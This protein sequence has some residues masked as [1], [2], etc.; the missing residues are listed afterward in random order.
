[1]AAILTELAAIARLRNS[2]QGITSNPGPWR[3][4]YTIA[5]CVTLKAP[6]MCAL[7]RSFSSIITP[8]CTHP[9]FGGKRA[10]PRNQGGFSGPC[11]GAVARRSSTG[12]L[13]EAVSKQDQEILLEALELGAALDA[14][15]RL[16]HMI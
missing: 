11:F 1:V 16:R 13:D 2:K 10:H 9:A 6:S 15:P 4:P 8:C 12:E 14:K 7:E 3:I 5:A